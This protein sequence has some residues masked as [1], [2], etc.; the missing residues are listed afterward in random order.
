[1][2]LRTSRKEA[3]PTGPRNASNERARVDHRRAAQGMPDVDQ[4]AL[5]ISALALSGGGIRSATVAFGVIP[6]TCPSPFPDNAT[7]RTLDS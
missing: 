5:G 1:M 4:D 6:R 2:E 7:S 3:D